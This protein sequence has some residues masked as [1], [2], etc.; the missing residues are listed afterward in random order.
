MAV[1]WIILAFVAVMAI[2]GALALRVAVSWGR[3]LLELQ[4]YGTEV[5]GRVLEKRQRR[6]RHTTSTWIRYEYAD[7][8]GKTHRSRR[9]LATPEAWNALV[10]GGPIAVVYSQRRPRVSFPRYLLALEKEKAVAT[11]K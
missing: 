4:Q 5:T 11:L 10:E 8:V 6:Q 9:H 3:E 1:V 2:A 7:Q